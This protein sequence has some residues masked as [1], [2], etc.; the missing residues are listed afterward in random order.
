MCLEVVIGITN[1]V[2]LLKLQ[3]RI[4][5]LLSPKLT[6]FSIL[7]IAHPHRL[8]TFYGYCWGLTQYFLA[9][10]ILV[11]RCLEILGCH[12]LEVPPL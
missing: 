9:L 7:H 5:W 10:S 8:H 2:T 1:D 11:I 6:L 3:T 4:L 12:T